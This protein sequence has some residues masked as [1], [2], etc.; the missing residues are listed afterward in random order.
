MIGRNVM[1]QKPIGTVVLRDA[2]GEHE[3]PLSPRNLYETALARFHA[4]MDG[5][6]AP[7]ASGE[8]G[9]WSLASGLAVAQSA[10]S[11]AAVKIEPG[12]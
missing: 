7:S 9:C 3:L 11:G 6:G 8:D 12:L 1:T 5:Q 2:S 10:A 4:A